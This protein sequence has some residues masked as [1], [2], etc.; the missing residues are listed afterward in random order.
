MNRLHTTPR[1]ANTYQEPH[2]FTGIM[3]TRC[4]MCHKVVIAYD[5]ETA[6]LRAQQITNKPKTHAKY[7]YIMKAY[8]GKC[9][10]WH[11]SRGKKL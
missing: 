5:E 9:G 2:W 3:K 7:A 6:H 10:H 4:S 1:L 11:V 8:K